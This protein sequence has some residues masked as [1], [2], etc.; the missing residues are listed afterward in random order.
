MMVK[1]LLAPEKGTWVLLC[2]VAFFG[3]VVAVNA[4]FISTALRTHSGV[5]TDQPYEKGLAYNETLAQA[6][7]QPAVKHDASW[8]D[9]VLSWQLLDETDE[10]IDA[11]VSA[12]L[13]R[14]VKDG[15]DFKVEMKPAGNGLYKARVDL[16]MKGRWEA[17]L[18]ALWNNSQYQTRFVFVAN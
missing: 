8:K 15:S 5:V 17:Q 3:L 14:S 11:E 18:K 9:G 16:P 12:L 10:P 13:Y 7:A 6:R 1:S 2:F 4:V